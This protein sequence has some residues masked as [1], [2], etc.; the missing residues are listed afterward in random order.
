MVFCLYL[1]TLYFYFNKVRK[2]LVI[3]MAVMTFFWS[4]Q[5]LAQDQSE[6]EYQCVA[7][8]PEP[9]VIPSPENYSSPIVEWLSE[10]MVRETIQFDPNIVVEIEHGGCAHYALIFHFI[11]QGEPLLNLTQVEW[12]KRTNEYLTKIKI[13][14]F[15]AWKENMQDEISKM[16]PSFSFEEGVTTTPGYSFI[17]FFVK[18]PEKNVTSVKIWG[19][20][21][22]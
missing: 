9:I 12:V 20:I 22:L 16:E 13:N 8:P 10:T 21:A 6:D 15:R 4:D 14:T 7:A 3:S 17:Y 19:D 18:E 1:A 2:I 5:T 11:F